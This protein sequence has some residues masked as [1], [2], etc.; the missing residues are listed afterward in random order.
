MCQAQD[1]ILGRQWGTEHSL[2]PQKISFNGR[3]RGMP[4]NVTH[5]VQ[6]SGH[7]TVMGEPSRETNV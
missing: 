4:R 5:S 1:R 2:G 3:K 6:S 7:L